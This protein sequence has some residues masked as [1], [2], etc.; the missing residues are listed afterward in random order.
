MIGKAASAAADLLSA[1]DYAIAYPDSTIHYHG[2]RLLGPDL[3]AES[4][5]R[6]NHALRTANDEYARSLARK[7]EL[8]FFF[9]YIVNRSEFVS[10]RGISGQEGWTELDCF[11][12]FVLTK[13]SPRARPVFERAKARWHRYQAL[14][15]HVIRSESRLKIGVETSLQKESRHLKAIVDFEVKGN[16]KNDAWSFRDEGMSRLAEDFFLL[17][18]YL[19]ASSDERL[20]SLYKSMGRYMISAEENEVI[21]KITDEGART[22]ALVGH[23]RSIV[24]PVWFFFISLCHALQEGENELSANDAYWLGL[25]DEVMGEELPASRWFE[26]FDPDAPGPTVAFG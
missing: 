20:L 11:I 26:E 8:R 16:R 5:P 24:Q 3:T 14:L 7:I 10:V 15:D 21:S 19:D 13:L 9:R 22:N 2:M 18:E 17:N 23:A 1:G 12:H 25:V 6:L 4:S